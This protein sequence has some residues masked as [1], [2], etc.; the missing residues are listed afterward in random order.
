MFFCCSSPDCLT[1]P[2]CSDKPMPPLRR[3]KPCCSDKPMPSLRRTKHAHLYTHADIVSQ[4]HRLILSFTLHQDR[5]AL[6]AD[7][8]E[9]EAL[10]S[11]A[12]V[13][14]DTQAAAPSKTDTAEPPASTQA[15]SA[16]KSAS[17]AK[18]PPKHAGNGTDLIAVG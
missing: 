1:K 18:A 13:C 12:S 9:F 17:A 5:I 4:I 6:E 14:A 15:H 16:G 10:R 7:R 11:S 3:T 2:C 8:N